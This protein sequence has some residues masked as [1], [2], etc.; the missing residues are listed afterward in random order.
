MSS[1]LR[2]IRNVWFELRNPLFI[3]YTLEQRELS[4]NEKEEYVK[5]YK[6]LNTKSKICEATGKKYH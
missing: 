3:H 5:L 6:E 1:F 2:L 4:Q